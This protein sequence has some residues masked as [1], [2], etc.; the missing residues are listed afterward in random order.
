MTELIA[1]LEEKQRK[2]AREVD[3][4]IAARQAALAVASPVTHEDRIAARQAALAAS[5]VRPAPPPSPPSPHRGYA[6]FEIALER[7]VKVALD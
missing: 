5:A 4:R 3:D 1:K 6:M 7:G 2:V